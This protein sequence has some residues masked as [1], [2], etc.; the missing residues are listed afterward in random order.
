MLQFRYEKEDGIKITLSL[1]ENVSE[2]AKNFL[3]LFNTMK[4]NKE[5]FL[6]LENDYGNYVFVTVTKQTAEQAKKFL[7]WYGEIIEE[8]PVNVFHLVPYYDGA[9]QNILYEERDGEDV[10]PVAVVDLPY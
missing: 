3:V 10:E 5:D 8:T 4:E 7:A 6:K 2:Y 1:P 9:G